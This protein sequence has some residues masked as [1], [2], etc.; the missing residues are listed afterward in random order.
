MENAIFT[1]RRKYARRT[2]TIM[3][4]AHRAGVSTA[5]VS[6]AITTPELVAEDTRARVTAAIAE[7][8]Y[9]PNATARNLRARST[10]TVLALLPGMSNTF[11]TP[12]LNALEDTLSA[13]GYGLLIGDTRN[14]PERERL[15]ARLIRAGQVDGV[16]LFTG[17]LPRDDAP[18]AAEDHPPVTLICNEIPGDQ[19][20]SVFD[21]AN[22]DAAREAVEHLIAAGHS[23]IAHIA[24][25]P[26]NIEARE[27]RRGYAEALVRA[28]IAFDVRIVWGDSFRWQSGVEA[29][30]HF[31]ASSNRP[32]AVFASSDDAAIGFIKTLRAANLRTPADVSVVGFDDIDLADVI[33]PPLTTMRQ[34]RSE[35]G[36][37]AAEDI[38]K[39]MAAG[40]DASPTRM[41]LPCDL[42]VRESVRTFE[43]PETAR[44]ARRN[45]GAARPGGDLRPEAAQ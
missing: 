30:G 6:R 33:D 8:G 25:P 21:V 11:F 29:A 18:M 43:A 27:R 28:G 10:R 42:I 37:L 1:H 44:S 23:R 17:H 34:P 15:Y 22:R 14:D 41:R 40:H 4:V 9:T 24:G 35:L 39:R 31:L 5:T 12:I 3:D 2:T 32:T 26:D 45:R 38:L 7:T 19:A 20:H 36:R 13:A 16:I